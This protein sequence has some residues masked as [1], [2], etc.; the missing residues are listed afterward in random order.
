M[1]EERRGRA[2]KSLVLSVWEAHFPAAVLGC[3]SSPGWPKDRKGDSRD[4]PTVG[5]ALCLVSQ[6]HCVAACRVTRMAAVWSP[7]LLLLAVVGCLPSLSQAR[8]PR[9]PYGKGVPANINEEL[10]SQ[11]NV[12]YRDTVLDHFGW[13]SRNTSPCFV[14]A[15]QPERLPSATGVCS[16]QVA[17]LICLCVTGVTKKNSTS[18]HQA[19]LFA[20]AIHTTPIPSALSSGEHLNLPPALFCVPKVVEGGWPHFLL[21]GQ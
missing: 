5:Q 3:P 16:T 18:Y 21:P 2:A 11:C 6:A 14:C 19:T 20:P 12:H 15:F 10:I 4:N 17:A 8:R 7:L 1:N 9:G 13:V